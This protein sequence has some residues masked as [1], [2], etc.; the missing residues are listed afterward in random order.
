MTEELVINLELKKDEEKRKVMNRF[1]GRRIAISWGKRVMRGS[2]QKLSGGDLLFDGGNGK[3][4]IWIE[5][6]KIVWVRV[7]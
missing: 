2:I 6:R 4:P 7:Y 1:V 3:H 5:I